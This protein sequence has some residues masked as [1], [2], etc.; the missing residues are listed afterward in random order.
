M[1]AYIYICIPGG[2][3]A[4]LA[5]GPVIPFGEDVASEDLPR[6]HAMVDDLMVH[7][8]ELAEERNAG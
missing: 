8:K 5:G 7:E 1:C 6:V 3:R 2:K 4:G